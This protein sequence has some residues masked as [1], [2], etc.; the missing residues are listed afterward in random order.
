MSNFI[1]L[2]LR[3]L[4]LLIVALV[5]AVLV[6]VNPF[7]IANII[8]WFG[9]IYLIAH[10][11][12]E[13]NASKYTTT[14]ISCITFVLLA[15]CILA[16]KSSYFLTE[17]NAVYLNN[18]SHVFPDWYFVRNWIDDFLNALL[19]LSAWKAK[20]S[21]TMANEILSYNL[22]ANSIFDLRLT[23]SIILKTIEYAGILLL[24]YF[25]RKKLN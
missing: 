12:Q 15:Y 16:V 20:T 2:F 14:M 3:L 7:P 25:W 24:P 23:G 13:I 22:G 21:F 9:L 6:K 4:F 5:Y 17:F 8:L 11:T 18:S 10:S 19:G 1:S